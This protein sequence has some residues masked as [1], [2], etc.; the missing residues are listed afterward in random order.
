MKNE[1]LFTVVSKEAPEPV[2]QL[3]VITVCWNAL[4]DLKPT[5]ESVLR[6][7]TKGS[8]SIEHVIVDGAST[9]GT[10]EWLAEQLAA[11]NIERYV[12]EPDRGIYDAMNKGINLARGEVLAFLNAGDTYTDEDLAPCVLPVCRGETYGTAACA[13]RVDSPLGPVCRPSYGQLFLYTPCCH[14]AY[15]ASAGAYRSMNGYDARHLRCCADADMMYRMYRNWGEPGISD[16]FVVNFPSGG[17]STNCDDDFRDENVELLWRNRDLIGKRCREDADFQVT[18]EAFLAHHCRQFRDWQ[19]RHGKMIPDTLCKL[20]S[21]C[22][23]LAKHAHSLYAGAALRW[24]AACYLPI[25]IAGRECS[26]F[27][28]RLARFWEHACYI[29][30]QNKYKKCLWLPNKPLRSHPL[31]SKFFPPA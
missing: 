10:P 30:E 26:P 20:Q 24:L 13:Y 15:F 4:E 27:R 22:R 28:L 18:M 25:L 3:T 23:E 9:D 17:M 2:Y 16:L 29:P 31:L 12:S 21:L 14:Q 19:G 7:K 5:V 8:I 11:G 6:Q 1:I